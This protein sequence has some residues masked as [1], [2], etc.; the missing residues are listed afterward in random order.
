MRLEDW[1]QQ[2]L[3]TFGQD[4]DKWRFRCPDCGHVQAPGDFL[5]LGM[6]RHQVDNRAG[7]SCI[8]RWTDQECMSAG[9]GTVGL[10]VTPGEIRPTFP[11]DK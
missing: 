6:H 8:R 11:F 7:Y 5:A 4:P 1:Q 10:H 2:G 3:D 9:R